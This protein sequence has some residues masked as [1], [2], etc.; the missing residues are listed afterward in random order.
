MVAI[1]VKPNQ[2][3]GSDPRIYVNDHYRAAVNMMARAQR[4][5]MRGSGKAFSRNLFAWFANRAEGKV[6]TA[7]LMKTAPARPWPRI[8][9]I[10]CVTWN[11]QL[12][13]VAGVFNPGVQEVPGTEAFLWLVDH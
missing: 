13:L 3:P 8:V 9:R 12:L 5:T 6:P 10:E 2:H 4:S 7:W 11:M 1:T